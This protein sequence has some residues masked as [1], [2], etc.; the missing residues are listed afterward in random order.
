MDEQQ[1]TRGNTNDNPPS[2][3]ID[4]ARDAALRRIDHL[5][6][7]VAQSKQHIREM[8][9]RIGEQN[10]RDWE[11]WAG[12]DLPGMLAHKDV[13]VR[14]LH[15]DDPCLRKTAIA[16]LLDHWSCVP[17]FA[18][19]LYTVAMEDTDST[20]QEMALA[21]LG[22]STSGLRKEKLRKFFSMIVL[23]ERKASKLRLC[24]YN[25][26]FQIEGLPSSS[27]PTIRMLKGDFTFPDDVDWEF[28]KR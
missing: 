12:A 19:N 27:W 23:D 8:T 11:V 13:T 24:A 21:A 17:E 10:R 22:S 20:V 6:T 5:L 9:H 4:E 16:L 28:V 14:Y 25:L 7:S 3:G 18:S 26:L 1:D 2:G 15:H